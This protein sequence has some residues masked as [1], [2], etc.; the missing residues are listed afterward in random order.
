MKR[1]RQR[2]ARRR[3]DDGA[4]AVEFALI[5]IPLLVLVLGIIQFG[6]IFYSQ[7]MLSQAAR[8]GARALSLNLG[9]TTPGTCDS[10]CLSTVKQKTVDSAAPVVSLDDSSF[11]TLQKCPAGATQS[12]EAVVA[13]HYKV[14]AALLFTITINGKSSFPCGG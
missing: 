7:I 8:E 11:D 12:D 5:S 9:T 14:S 3:G 1:L 4:A 2:T 10:S 6:F 13:V